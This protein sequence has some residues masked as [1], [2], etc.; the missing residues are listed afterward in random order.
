MK[1]NAV[2]KWFKLQ[3]QGLCQQS[4]STELNST[5]SKQLIFLYITF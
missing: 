5:S 1:M 2:Q 4:S 3:F